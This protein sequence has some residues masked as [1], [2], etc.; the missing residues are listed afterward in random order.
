MLCIPPVQWAIR[1]VAFYERMVLYKGYAPSPRNGT[2]SRERKAAHIGCKHSIRRGDAVHTFVTLVIFLYLYDS[3]PPN[4]TDS[5]IALLSTGKSLNRELSRVLGPGKKI[6]NSL[7]FVVSLLVA[8][9]ALLVQ[10][11]KE[12][13]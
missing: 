4:S 6:S 12:L 7:S 8:R 9:T 2:Q 11:E 3:S 10:V 13:S 5:T 1:K